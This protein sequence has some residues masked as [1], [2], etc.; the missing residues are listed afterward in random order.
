MKLVSV[1]DLNGKEKAAFDLIAK[2]FPAQSVCVNV[3]LGKETWDVRPLILVNGVVYLYRFSRPLPFDFL[4]N[5]LAEA[6]G[7]SLLSTW[8]SSMRGMPAS[9]RF[10]LVR[11]FV[12]T[13]LSDLLA[14]SDTVAQRDPLG[15]AK[16]LIEQVA[17]LDRRRLVHGHIVP[18]NV[19]LNASSVPE[20][21]FLLDPRIGSLSGRKDQDIAPELEALQDPTP[22][23][24][25]YGLG[26][27]L[28]ALCEGRATAAQQEAI[29]RLLLASPRQ[30]PS[31][32]EVAAVF[33][34][35][36]SRSSQDSPRSDNQSARGRIITANG[37]SDVPPQG[38]ASLAQAESV[39]SADP[40]LAE[41]IKR[42]P[43]SSSSLRFM[44]RAGGATIL[45]AIA[46]LFLLH[47]R[48]PRAYNLLGYYLPLLVQA[49]DPNHVAALASGDRSRI[50]SVV[51]AAV[52]DY[53]LAALN[54]IT[55]DISSGAPR[56]DFNRA[57]MQAA[58]R[59][60]WKEGFSR[61]DLVTLVALTSAKLLPEALAQLPALSSLH[62]AIILAVASQLPPSSP[63]EQFKSIPVD[64]LF[65]LGEV[66]GAAFQRLKAVGVKTLAE[67]QAVALCHVIAGS[68]NASAYDVLLG[69]ATA[70]VK[71][72]LSRLAT[73]LPLV[74]S[75]SGLSEQ[76]L[77]TIR[78][79]GGDLG[80]VLSWFDIDDLVAWRSTHAAAKLL[81]LLEQVPSVGLTIS[82]YADLL[83]FPLPAVREK[84]AG[85][86]HSRGLGAQDA[87]VL[88]LLTSDQN[89]LTRAQ[90]VAL[91]SGLLLETA[92]RAPFVALW[93]Q[94][95]P[96]PET[97]L[98][99]LI[100][101]AGLNDKDLFNLE[102][103]R[104]LKKQ[105]SWSASPDMLRLLAVHPE[106]LAR[107]LAYAKLDPSDA[108]QKKILQ[109]R[110]SSEKDPA[111]L[112]LVTTKLAP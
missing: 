90:T 104:Y 57:L 29:D 44:W 91:I 63:G 93:F 62:P 10:L 41:L 8:N 103:A 12:P 26:L 19:A 76:L 95:A 86:L 39:A 72:T 15:I 82:Q 87:Q 75:N 70:P 25:L 64:S 98:L 49:H 28:K 27:C 85:E 2:T 37:T 40:Q 34:K 112:K 45:V 50:R 65:S 33:I 5:L 99:I 101:R 97:T 51:R 17:E 36:R 35:G 89:R 7:F 20:G 77:V 38:V 71:E 53:D 48:F 14:Q 11:P 66:E 108:E 3:M 73:V 80:T 84:V 9:D 105:P 78:D 111:L 55:E 96:P 6:D 16:A 18:S 61:S 24:D 30:R 60:P 79:R 69:D 47:W 23:A 106:P 74:M 81:L 42:L 107:S 31:L 21:L 1:D 4:R 83:K 43:F 94:M 59:S 52:I 68:A 88:T 58:Y 54:A 102:A 13:T 92:K 110:V 109:D 100:A 56:P 32:A 46:L 67:P 22:S